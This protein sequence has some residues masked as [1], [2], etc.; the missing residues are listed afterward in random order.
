MKV[1]IISSNVQQSNSVGK[2]ATELSGFLNKNNVDTKIMY[3]SGDTEARNCIKIRPKIISS[4]VYRTT[5]FSRYTIVKT[6][7]AINKIK[8]VIKE[9]K[10]DVIHLVQPLIR[11]I[12]NEGLFRVIG[13]SNIPCVYSMIDENAYLGNCDNAYECEQ[14]KK[15][16]EYCKGE[17][18]EI[19]KKVSKCWCWSKRGSIRVAHNKHKGYDLINKICFVAPEWVVER[20]KSSEL[21]KNKKFYI[22]DEYVN[23]KD[24]YYP[25]NV[26]N[27]EIL[28]KYKIDKTKIIILNVAKYS[29]PRKGIKYFIELAK[30]LENDDRYV[31]VNIGYDGPLENLPKNYIAVPFVSNQNEL[32]K[33]Y[34]L[35]DLSMITSVSDT[36]PNTSLEALSCGTPVCGFN[37][38]GIPYVANEP[39][40][41]YVE[42]RNVEQLVDVVKS[43][44]KKTIDISEECREYALDRYSPEVS[45]NKMLAIYKDMLGEK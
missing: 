45:G 4:I 40:G 12:D 15:G 8:K 6:P 36:M 25:R 42:P 37:I 31:F 21:L 20:A 43:T 5:Q 1:L 29:N 33:F 23:N 7:Y 18:K 24:V 19:N 14:F 30:M 28:S 26:K 2:I 13:E 34:S 10:P 35:A 38:T 39:L 22:V 3:F 9:Y 41:I 32:A 11:F 44:T 17:N 16:C 27:S